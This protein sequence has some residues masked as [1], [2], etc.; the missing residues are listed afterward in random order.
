MQPLNQIMNWSFQ[1]GK[2]ARI[3]VRVH[4]FLLIF[5][6]Y[7]VFNKNYDGWWTLAFCLGMTT[8]VLLHELGHALTA[9]NLGLRPIQ[10]MLHPFG[11]WAESAG[12]CTA[13][14][15]FQIVAMG[16]AVNFALAGVLW[17]LQAL[18]EPR[19]Q[20]EYAIQV[21]DFMYVMAHWN[22]YMGA[23]NLLPS[24]PLDGGRIL[25]SILKMRGNRNPLRVT[26]IT[27]LV[28]SV[29]LLGAAVITNDNFLIFFALL[30]GSSSF[31][32]YQSSAGAGPSRRDV[33]EHIKMKERERAK[34]DE[35][36]DRGRDKER[37]RE[38]RERLRKLFSESVDKD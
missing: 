8:S 32:A 27:G 11:G 30:T 35:Y 3:P 1:A 36:L 28:A 34:A 2:I 25:E 23:L 33:N 26:A 20:S 17:V 5:V 6:G 18:L 22:L 7:L 24:L 4:I 29:L 19:V 16:P 12:R 21:M 31:F 38:E 14:Q 10:I 15:D 13:R 9:R 37:Q